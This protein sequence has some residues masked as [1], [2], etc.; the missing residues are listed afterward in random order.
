MKETYQSVIYPLLLR[1]GLLWQIDNICPAQEHFL[2]VIIRQKL[3]VAI[4]DIPLKTQNKSTWL[5]FLPEDEEH[6]I[7]LLFASY[8][9]RSMGH[10]VIFLGG[11]VPIASVKDVIKHKKINH[12]LL[13]MVRSRPID[14]ASTYLKELTTNLY[15]ISFHLAGNAKLIN[16]LHLD[17][18]IK[19]YKSISEFEQT[20]KNLSNAN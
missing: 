1:L 12:V 19:C 16:S 6:D 15:Q 18:N 20:I 5:L 14:T 11:R 3:L 13:F 2:T 4:N 9:L 10:Q 7:G 17:K 8:L